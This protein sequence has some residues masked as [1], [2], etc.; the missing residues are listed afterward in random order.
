VVVNA[1]DLAEV[2]GPNLRLVA[3]AAVD[4][5][6]MPVKQFVIFDAKLQ[7][8]LPVRAHREMLQYPVSLPPMK[9]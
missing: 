5:V 4:I 3:T 2:A 6:R 9:A 7:I 1:K 8:V